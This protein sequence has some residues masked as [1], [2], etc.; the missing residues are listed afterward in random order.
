MFIASQPIPPLT[1]PSL[2]IGFNSLIRPYEEKPVVDK[3][4]LGP[5]KI[6]GEGALGLTSHNVHV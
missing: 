1:Y 3:P 5:K 4:F 2:E 6:L